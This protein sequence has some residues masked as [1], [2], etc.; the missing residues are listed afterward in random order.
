MNEPANGFEFLK[1]LRQQNGNQK[2]DYRYF[3]SYLDHKARQRRIPM[4][5]QFE[6]SP[7]CNLDCKMCYVHLNAEQ[8]SGCSVLPPETWKELMRQAWEAG[9]VRATLSGGE[10]L[11]YPGFEELYLY[12][13]SLGCAVAVYTNGVLLDDKRVRFFT[14]H[15]PNRIQITLY[16][17][18]DDVYER[19][20]G[21]RAFK[22]VDANIRKAVD[23]GLP[24]LIAITPS[25]YLGED[26]FELLRFAR[27]YGR[28]I[29]VSH[30]VFSPREETGRSAQKDDLSID[31]HIR[32]DQMLSELNGIE[33]KTIDED[34]LPPYG[35]GAHTCTECGLTCGGGRSS[36]SIDWK[37]TLSPCNRLDAIHADALHEGFKAA[38]DTVSR[39]AANWPRVPEC[40]G[41]AYRDVC[42]NC[43]AAMLEFAEPGKQPI[44]LCEQTRYY[45]QHGIRRIPDC[46]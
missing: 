40:E 43:A 18:N 38:W 35:G 4:W 29:A 25:K 15:R 6:L 24:V 10:C 9:M 27:G 46:D 7:Q 44:G 22:T 37:G 36:F 2:Q 8:L 23:A 33:V 42:Y 28:P 3:T 16:G 5:G 11:M 19:V 12:L 1:L 31:M 13:H 34:K 41:C 21:R 17:H 14:E 39:E 26:V 30:S 32:L 20:T 45:V